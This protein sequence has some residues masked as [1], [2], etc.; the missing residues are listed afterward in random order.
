MSPKKI[1]KTVRHLLR[2]WIRH[3]LSMQQI[4][5]R[6][7]MAST[8][9]TIN[10]TYKTWLLFEKEIDDYSIYGKSFYFLSNTTLSG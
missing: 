10:V 8:K 1:H 9:Q 4:G 5:V 7:Y 3:G 2:A 6:L